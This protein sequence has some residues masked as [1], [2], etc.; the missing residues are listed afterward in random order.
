MKKTLITTLSIGALI[1]AAILAFTG[2]VY[3]INQSGT[4]AEP[5]VIDMGGETITCVLIKGDYVVFQNAV[6]TGCNTFGIRVNGKHVKVLNNE[7]YDVARSNWDGSKC[8]GAGGWASGVRVADTSDV[9][10]SGNTVHG[11]CGEGIGILRADNILVENNIVY[12]A[13]SVNIYLDQTSN[14]VVR[15]NYS[16]S[17]GDVRFYKNG[18][19]ARGISIGAESYS[20]WSF[21]VHDILIENNKLE[22]VRGINYITETSGTPYNIVVR[23]NTFINVPAP[24]VSLGSWATV[25]TVTP[26][27]SIPPTVTKMP[28]RTTTPTKTP[29]PVFTITPSLTPAPQLICVQALSVVV[30]NRMP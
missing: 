14:A 20:N 22:K 13:F 18:Q 27:T 30:C 29:M 5:L 16:Y 15:N 7:I 1:V 17:T 3:T 12:D 9:V 2:D 6:V 11:L 21:S 23:N 19:V 10:V 24:L 26:G 4:A 28:T 25:G 8:S